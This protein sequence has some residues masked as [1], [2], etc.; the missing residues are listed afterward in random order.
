MDYKGLLGVLLLAIGGTVL[1]MLYYIFFQMGYSQVYFPAYP[2]LN[3][4]LIVFS[5]LGFLVFGLGLLLIV[6]G[7]KTETKQPIS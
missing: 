6:Q 5:F 2:S 4:V 3:P 1:F 7:G